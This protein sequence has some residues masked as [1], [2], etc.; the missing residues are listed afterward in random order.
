[1]NIINS[2]FTHTLKGGG[3]SLYNVHMCRKTGGRADVPINQ[4]LGHENLKH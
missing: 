1:M 3:G 2:T 4:E